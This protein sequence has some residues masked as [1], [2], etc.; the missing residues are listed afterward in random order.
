MNAAVKFHGEPPTHLTF[1]TLEALG[2][3]HA[4]TTRDCPGIAHPSEPV[5]PMEREAVALLEPAGLDLA[6]VAFL[7]QV[8]GAEVRRIE[9]HR[10]GYAGEGDVLVTTRP[11]VPL[12]V[13]TADCL[14]V[15]VFDPAGRGLALAHVG[16]RGTV[17]SALPAA[18]GALVS[19]GARPEDLVAAISPSIGPCC[20][21]VDR[22]VIE[23]L[24]A[25]FPERW[26]AWVNPVGP[27]KWR[28]DLWAA[29][30]SQLEAAGL[31]PNRIANARLCTACRTD[32][33]FSYR[34]EGSRGRLV[35]LAALG[36]R[37]APEA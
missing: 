2:L 13:F 31:R 10:G 28:L 18:V 12:A 14:A 24:S 30:Q 8:H 33:F 17:K 5:S 37:P 19:V 20:Y 23:P 11:G 15:I 6:R 35:T 1:P 9:D 34:K 22:P 4:S 16:W 27:G 32:L 21:E 25:A 36:S 3:W 7:R 26:Q 29:N